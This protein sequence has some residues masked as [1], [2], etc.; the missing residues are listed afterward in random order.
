MTG[1]Q[2]VDDETGTLDVPG[3][4]I[5]PMSGCDHRTICWFPRPN[6]NGYL[7]V[8]AHIKKLAAGLF[9]PIMQL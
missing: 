8:L 9:I 1:I 5:V 4:T 3:E 6:S 7:L 2:I